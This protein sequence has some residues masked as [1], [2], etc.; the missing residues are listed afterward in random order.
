MTSSND[1]RVCQD[2]GKTKHRN[3]FGGPTSPYPTLCNPCFLVFKRL[4]TRFAVYGL[5]VDDYEWFLEHQNNACAL[6]QKPPKQ[7]YALVVD[8]DHLDGTVRGLLCQ[9]CNG[10]LSG[11]RQNP[12]WLRRA[13]EYTTQPR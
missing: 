1:Y 13:Y 9:R 11:P 6:C 2:C 7:K 10:M 3:E 5:S 12:D 8:H 4:N